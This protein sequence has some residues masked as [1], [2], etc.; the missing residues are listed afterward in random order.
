MEFAPTAI[1]I[2]DVAQE[3]VQTR[4]YNAFSYRDLAERVG[5]RTASIHY[6]FPVKADLGKA[7]MARY[8]AAVM[9]ALEGIE[10]AVPTDPPEKLRRYA[11][12]LEGVLT[13]GD[14]VCLGGML[15]SDYAT[16][17]ADLQREVRRFIDANE[18]WLEGV[19]A[20][21]RNSGVFSFPGEPRSVATGLFSGLEG[22]MLVARS[23]DDLERYRSTAGWLLGSLER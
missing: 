14:R 17:P 2:L 15:A 13:C 3:L 21:G 10:A 7:L 20:S 6:H 12:V 22:A 9:A 11:S 8:H 23:C 5:I 18:A 16:L 1:Q 4:G 19:L